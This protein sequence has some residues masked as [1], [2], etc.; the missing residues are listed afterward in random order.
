M[1]KERT[2]AGDSPELAPI[3]A[4]QAQ[5]ILADQELRE[6]CEREGVDLTLTVEN[7]KASV[8]ERLDRLTQGL[9][10]AASLYDAGTRM[11]LHE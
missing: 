5:A 2:V 11:G 6:Q 1:A 9:E 7:L 10:L 8:G 3:T 4:E